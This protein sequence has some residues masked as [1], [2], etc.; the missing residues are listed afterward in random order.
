MDPDVPAAVGN[1]LREVIPWTA[2]VLVPPN[3][4]ER[5][6]E[7]F[8]PYDDA[9]DV[10]LEDYEPGMRTSEIREIFAVLTPEL[11]ALVAEH[12]TDEE[13]E[14]MRGPFPVD[15]QEALRVRVDRELGD[16]PLSA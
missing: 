1:L 15:R 8:A 12:A 16:H 13:D 14:F 9:Y 11:Q 10:L 3:W 7:C 6:I 5:Y 4:D 2:A